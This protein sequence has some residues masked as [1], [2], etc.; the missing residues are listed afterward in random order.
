MK[1]AKEFFL[2]NR[3]IEMP[4]GIVPLTWFIENEIPSTV[5]CSCCETSMF[6]TSAMIDDEGY[7]YCSNCI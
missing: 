4:D 7:I 6:L 1:T 3:N 2:E 5:A